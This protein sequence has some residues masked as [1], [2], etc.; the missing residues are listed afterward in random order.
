R[1]GKAS[2]LPALRRRARGVGALPLVDAPTARVDAERL[3]RVVDLR[4]RRLGTRA[5]LRARLAQFLALRR[6]ARTGGGALGSTGAPAASVAATQRPLPARQ[7]AQLQP[8]VLPAL[9]ASLHRL[10]APARSPA[11]LAGGAR[12]GDLSALP[13][14]KLAFALALALA[15]AVALNW[16]YVAQ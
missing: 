4:D 5:R 8:E 3:Q 16:G 15:S 2:R 9:G 13:A 12:C 10:R 11:R 14:V 6:T 1:S 7:S